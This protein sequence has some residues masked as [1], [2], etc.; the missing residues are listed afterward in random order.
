[1]S[2]AQLRRL[3]WGCGPVT[4]RGWV[5]CDKILGP[6]VD[7]C[8]D[9]RSGLP[10]RDGSFDYAVGVHVLQDLAY[11]DVVPALRELRRVLK[12]DGVLR[13][14]L[15]DLERALQAHRANDR[16]YFY[17]PD[18]DA[19]TVDGKLAVQITWYGSVRTP[20][21]F[22]F[23]AELLERS[24]FRRVVRCPFGETASRHSEIAMLDNRP[25][26]SVCV[27]ASRP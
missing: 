4:A 3:N 25:R 14:V 8:C 1:M 6:G 15:P 17:V 23:A 9:V 11:P 18:E 20:F 27:E 13:L 22:A 5:N 2:S 21:T 12:P 19:A 24:G 26:E 10:L 7:V 16:A